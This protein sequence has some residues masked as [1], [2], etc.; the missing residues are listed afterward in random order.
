MTGIQIKESEEI[1]GV[2]L[3]VSYGTAS[4]RGVVKLENGTLP[5]DAR[6]FI[7]VT[8][9]G[10]ATSTSRQPAVD[11]RGHFILEGLPG[12]TYDFVTTVYTPGSQRRPPPVANQQVTVPDG[13]VTE[14]T[15]TFDLDQKISPQS[16]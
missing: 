13:V 10:E 8:K 2:R 11:A 7:R 15:I 6:I 3:V 14:V 12:G 5:A 9:V 1:T 4:I 16:P